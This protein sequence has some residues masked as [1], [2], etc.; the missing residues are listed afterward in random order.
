MDS[1]KVVNFSRKLRGE[2]LE[3]YQSKAP[4]L[5]LCYV[6]KLQGIKSSEEA[7][8]KYR[9][10]CVGL[11]FLEKLQNGKEEEMSTIMI[12]LMITTMRD[13]LKMNEKR[14]MTIKKRPLLSNLLL[15]NI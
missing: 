4:C 7:K 15:F 9:N 13:L 10:P 14:S 6:S 2:D 8:L 3:P 11:C 12:P 5:R 1:D